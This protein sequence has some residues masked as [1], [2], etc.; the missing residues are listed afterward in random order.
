MNPLFYRRIVCS[1]TLIALSAPVAMRGQSRDALIGDSPGAPPVA[2][3]PV[4]PTGNGSISG[5]VRDATGA[6]VAHAQ[7]VLQPGAT[8][9][10]SNAQGDFYIQNVP[11]GKYTVTIS[12]VGFQNAV[13]TIVVKAG[14]NT[15]V[16]TTMKLAS[17]SQQ[18]V[19]NAALQGDVAAINEQRTSANILNVMTAQQIQNLPNQSIATVLGRMPGVT[20]QINEGEAQYVQIRGTEPRLSN[21]TLDDVLVPGPDP[22]VRQ[23]DLWVIPADLVGAV[24][25]NKT[26]SANEDGDAIGGSV[27]MQMKQATSGRPTINLESLGGY[28]PIDTGQPWF[29]DDATIG[30]RFGAKQRFGLI[31]SYSYDLND[32]GTDDVEPVPVPAP[33]GSFAPY[34]NEIAIQQYF[35]NHTRWG[36]GGSADYKLNEGSDFYAHGLFSNF[37]DYGQKYTYDIVSATEDSTGASNDDGG[38]TYSTSVRRPNYQISLLTLGG[39]QV[40]SKWW[41]KYEVSIGHSREG[42][43]AGNPGADFAPNDPSVGSHC[44]YDPAATLKISVYRPQFPC[45]TDPIYDASQ[46]SLQDINTT[47][48]QATQLN[49]EGGASVGLN[50][51]VGTHASTLEFGGRVRNVH[52]GQYAFQPTY[53][54]FSGTAPSMT[55]FTGN[56]KDPDF[57]S[58]TYQMGPVKNFDLISKWLANNPTDLPLDEAATHLNSDPANYNLQERI[59]AGYVMN[60]L[61]L[62][63]RASLQTGLRIEATNESNTGFLVTQDT[64]G[65]YLAT[66]PVHATGSYVSPLP[67]IQFRYRLDQD[68]DIRAVFGRGISRPNPY[69]LVPYKTLDESRTP[70][71]ESI[72]NPALV[73][74]HAN[75]YDILYEHFLPS[76]GMIE[77]GYFYK[78]LGQPLVQTQT[79]VPNTFPN[80]ITPTV[81]LSQTINSGHAYVQGIEFAY[82]QHLDFLPG[83]LSG[84]RIDTNFT[85]T[86]SKDYG[87]PSRSDSPPQLG[88]APYSFNITPSYAT[89]RAMVELGISYDGANIA[90]YQWQDGSDNLG[91]RGP[92]GDNYYYERTQVD[93]QATYYLGKGFSITASDENANNALL[94][95]YNGSPHYMTQ[96][97][98]YRP[99]YYGGIRWSPRHD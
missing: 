16:N 94:G 28:N 76:V 34:F 63:S 31:M 92:D 12:D 84:A 24:Q 30:K 49:L 9:A 44:I 90:A 56:F 46:Y 87:L 35:Y 73:A 95:F 26:L 23:V 96:R 72:G 38:I 70:N 18:V 20:V 88:Q 47:T 82:Q 48:G 5:T 97:E 22:Q 75:D 85:W 43:A 3:A 7:I 1:L 68:S 29:R 27:N 15:L 74:E 79:T 86:N 61:D 42:G 2:S 41:T 83:V 58:G 53:D 71:R 10:A 8:T 51:H 37:K 80:P 25:I 59:T 64:S 78:Q 45:G 52:K 62:G 33:D 19:V 36:F 17:T 14:Q 99:I 39:N 32:I 57:Y 54:N 4:A 11:V 91:V 81:L 66:S 98:Y 67:S 65:D 77:A 50:Y 60:T 13:S 21:T 93:A 55:L 89:K 69:D 40:F 6:V